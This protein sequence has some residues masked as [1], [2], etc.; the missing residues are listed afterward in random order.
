MKIEGASVPPLLAT[1]F[2][3]RLGGQALAIGGQADRLLTCAPSANAAMPPTLI[4]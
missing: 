2:L 3:P 4:L 1:C